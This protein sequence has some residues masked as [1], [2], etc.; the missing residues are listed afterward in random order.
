LLLVNSRPTTPEIVH[1]FIS[2][3]PQEAR[4]AK[5]NKI[6]VGLSAAP[7]S[8]TTMD[9]FKFAND[10]AKSFVGLTLA[11]IPSD[12]LRDPENSKRRWRSIPGPTFTSAAREKRLMHGS[13]SKRPNERAGGPLALFPFTRGVFTENSSNQT[14]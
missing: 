1:W 11:V 8:V 4:D 5:V 6:R 3:L 14:L 7:N 12:S 9:R 10:V 13:A 2:S